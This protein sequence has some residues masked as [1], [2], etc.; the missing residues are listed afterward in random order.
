[1]KARTWILVCIIIH[2][3]WPFTPMLKAKESLGSNIAGTFCLAHY[4]WYVIVC[5]YS[6]WACKNS[7]KEWTRRIKSSD[8]S[9]ERFLIN[10]FLLQALWIPSYAGFLKTRSVCNTKG[11]CKETASKQDL[12]DS[13]VI[14]Q[15]GKHSGYIDQPITGSGSE[16]WRSFFPLPYF[17]V[18]SWHPAKY[19]SYSWLRIWT[20]ANSRHSVCSFLGREL[21]PLNITVLSLFFFLFFLPSFI[22]FS[23]AFLLFRAAPA[24]YGSS[25]ARGQIRDVAAGLCHSHSNAGSKLHLQPIPWL[26]DQGQG[27]NPC[28]HGS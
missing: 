15:K 6:I 20:L 9:S 16:T 21:S 27:S 25:Q 7:P 12:E 28:P 24:A 17:T 3:S 1:M 23:L 13:E 14:L 26:T 4:L 2:T 11:I 10:L 19:S 18:K 5:K 22:F 8:N